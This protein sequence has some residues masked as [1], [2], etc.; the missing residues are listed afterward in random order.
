MRL[1]TLLAR[2]PDTARPETH[3]LR[4]LMLLHAARFPGRVEGGALRLLAAQ[5]RSAWDGVLLAEGMRALDRAAS[6]RGREP[7][8]PR[9]GDR[10]R[11]T[12]PRRRGPTPTG[13]TSSTL[14]DALVARW[15]SPVAALNRVIVL[16]AG[17]M[18]PRR[19]W[20]RPNRWPAIRGWR[21]TTCC[22]RCSPTC[23]HGWATAGAPRHCSTPRW[24]TRCPSRSGGCWPPGATACAR[25]NRRRDDASVEYLIKQYP[26]ESGALE[27]QYIEEFFGE[28]PR[29]KTAAE[30]LQRLRRPR[31]ADP[32]GR[33]GAARRAVDAASRWPTRSCTSCAG[34]EREPKLRDLVG[35]LDGCVNFDGRKVLYSWIGATRRDW[36]GQGHFRALTEQS[37]AWAVSLGYREV[38]VKTKNRFYDMR[39]VLA[40]LGFDVVKLE[41]A[42]GDVAESK[43]YLSKQLRPDLVSEHRSRRTVVQAER[44][45]SDT[46][47]VQPEAVEDVRQ[48]DA[49]AHRPPDASIGVPRESAG[50]VAALTP[51]CTRCRALVQDR[52]GIA[53]DHRQLTGRGRRPRQ[54]VVAGRNR[55]RRRIGVAHR[56][57]GR[58]G[59]A[60]QEP[61]GKGTRLGQHP[62]P[63][64]PR[65]L[66]QQESVA[67][68]E[69]DRAA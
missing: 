30:V 48:A 10:R 64:Q 16:A 31:I 61:F 46:G 1:V 42:A 57:A 54:D 23:M 15:P 49:Q 25:Y 21:A 8:P 12:P 55:R 9:S 66:P 29:R 36:R 69:R 28:F 11:A 68:S 39:A 53:I 41:R 63:G 59:D 60:G 22:R 67:A 17:R 14:Y 19:R 50:T 4:A 51:G 35:R 45:D 5:D 2:H 62:P 44:L 56:D 26:L 33:G 32:D 6:R 20:P 43:V 37:E 13:R 24:R 47:R 18:A 40:Q 7:L 3:A 58:P 65:R 34:V 38:V 27:I 52:G